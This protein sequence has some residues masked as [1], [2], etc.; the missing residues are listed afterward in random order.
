MSRRCASRVAAPAVIGAMFLAARE[1][2]GAQ[3]SKLVPLL[4][5][6]QRWVVAYN[7]H[8]ET[9]PPGTFTDDCVVIDSFPPFA[10]TSRTQG[11]RAWYDEL[12]GVHSA[13]WR[14]RV[15]QSRPNVQLGAP[16][17]VDVRGAIAY[18]TFHATWTGYGSTGRRSTQHATFTVVERKTTA[19]WR[20][21]AH[22]WGALPS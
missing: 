15:L 17:S 1:P 19:G 11:I 12:E 10:W 4:A 21:A 6:I 3:P 8:Q 18:M 14:H 5:P 2:A 22:S 20:I 16:T 7:R 9:F 13:Y